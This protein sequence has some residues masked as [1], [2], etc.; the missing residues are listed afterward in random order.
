MKSSYR[1]LVFAILLIAISV[2]GYSTPTITEKTEAKFDVQQMDVSL[3]NVVVNDL[4]VLNYELEKAEKPCF[5]QAKEKESSKIDIQIIT[6]RELSIFYTIK[7]IRINKIDR[8]NRFTD[9]FKEADKL[10]NKLYLKESTNLY[11]Q[12]LTTS[13][14]GISGRQNY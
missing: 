5:I 4:F 12:L 14:G 6:Q 13:S 10:F 3:E 9:R 8:I 7:S 1:F 11:R 2:V